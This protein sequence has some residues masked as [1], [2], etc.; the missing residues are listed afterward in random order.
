MKI[1]RP[2]KGAP[3]R[4]FD[5]RAR[6]GRISGNGPE[7]FLALVEAPPLLASIEAPP[8]EIQPGRPLRFTLPHLP[9]PV[10]WARRKT[11]GRVGVRP[12]GAAAAHLPRKP[13]WN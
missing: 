6:R 11:R 12:W 7:Q 8:H 5:R 4:R 1:R 2:G 3:N 9:R 13:A 10:R